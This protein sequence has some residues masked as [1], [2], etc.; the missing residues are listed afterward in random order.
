MSVLIDRATLDFYL[1][2]WLGLE[3]LLARAPFAEHSVAS[4]GAMLDTADKLATSHF[5]PF[6]KKGDVQEPYQD[7]DGAHVLPEVRRAIT[8]YAE[9]GFLAAGF[10]PELGGLGAPNLVHTA[11]TAYF[12]AANGPFAAY[13]F[14]TVGNANLIAHFGTPKQ[15]ETFVTPALEGRWTGTMCLSE[16][17]AGSSLAD[18]ITRAVPDGEDALGVRYKITGNKMWISGGDHDAAENIVHLVLAKIPDADGKLV[19]GSK[20]I[21]IFIVPKLLPGTSARNDVNLAGLNHK[22]GCRATSNCLLNLGEHG[23]AIGWRVGEIGQGLP[24]MFHMMNEARIAVGLGATMTG[25]RGYRLALDYARNRP[26]GRPLGARDVASKQIPIIEHADV[27]RMLLASKTYTEG[28]LALVLYCAKLVDDAATAATEEARAEAEAVLGLLTP[29][30]K[31]W[32]SEWAL[33][34]NELA[35]QV[36]GGYGY[37]R[38]FDVE[39]L[40]RDNRLNAIH[41]G[42][43][44]IQALDLLGRKILRDGG[45]ILGQFALRVRATIKS[46]P[47][48]FS[49]EAAALGAAMLALQ[50]CLRGLQGAHDEAEMLANATNFLSAFGHAVLG[51]VWLDIVAHLDAE[52]H[53]VSFVEGKKAAARFFFAFEMPKIAAW[54][55]PVSTRNGLTVAMQGGW[56]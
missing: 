34:A 12:M 33:A 10:A 2:D 47:A 56:F 39:Q 32:P 15:I 49:G 13:S 14:L 19:P 48:E 4:V 7:A 20:G 8:A 52:R 24:I 44:G 35:I 27:K 5:L 50:D 54:L 21:S 9:A 30:A 6:Y 16:P 25:Y 1:H 53:G 45:K 40:Y 17:Q 36:H 11:A 31:T 42:T 28:A 22:M 55:E 26:Q 18:I 38:D 43:T 3:T 37:T 41:E 23:G 29:V 51:F 46:A